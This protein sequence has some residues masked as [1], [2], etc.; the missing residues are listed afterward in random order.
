MRKSVLSLAVV[1]LLV[2]AASAQITSPD[3]MWAGTIDGNNTGQLTG[4]A[5]LGNDDLFETLFYEASD[6]GGV[7]QRVEANYGPIS[8][9][10][11]ANSPSPTSCPAASSP[12]AGLRSSRTPTWMRCRRW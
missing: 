1:A 3:G 10:I 4:V 7:T 8:Q 9:I 5:F 12:T 2:P 11:G 6:P